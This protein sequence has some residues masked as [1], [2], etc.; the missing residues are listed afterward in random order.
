MENRRNLEESSW[1]P[2]WESNP[3]GVKSPEDFKSPAYAI[4][5]PGL[6]GSSPI[7][8][9]ALVQSRRFHPRS[10]IESE[11]L[12]LTRCAVGT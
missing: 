5:P 3:H 12:L 4:S 1:C 8:P 6:I 2:G 10:S 11:T 9:K 7:L